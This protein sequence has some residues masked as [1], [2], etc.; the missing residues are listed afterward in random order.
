[1]CNA[2]STLNVEASE[3]FAG[4]MIDIASSGA[5][6]LMVSIGHRTRLFDT[7]KHSGPMSVERLA[8][9]DSLNPRYVREWLGAMVSGGIV[10]Y[11]EETAHYHLPDEHAAFLTRSASPDN[12]ARRCATRSARCTA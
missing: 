6:A 10:R 7:M 9:S 4:R 1:M 11:D 2:C 12:I 8:S 5:L 3:A